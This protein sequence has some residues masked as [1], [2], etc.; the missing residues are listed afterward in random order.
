MVR[1]VLDA[2]LEL[3]ILPRL[4]GRHSHTLLLHC[5]IA[6]DNFH[7]RI[8][9]SMQQVLSESA[10]GFMRRLGG[11]GIQNSAVFLKIQVPKV[12]HFEDCTARDLPKLTKTV[13]IRYIEKGDTALATYFGPHVALNRLD[14][15]VFHDIDTSSST[16]SRP[17][18]QHGTIAIVEPTDMELSSFGLV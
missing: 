2:E 9:L 12:R 3:D 5:V 13:K 15:R 18:L 11:Q 14:T 10:K 1:V 16:D 7:A 6:E 8:R 17:L 4:L